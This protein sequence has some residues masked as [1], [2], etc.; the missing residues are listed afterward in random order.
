MVLCK[1]KKY[2]SFWEELLQTSRQCTQPLSENIASRM[3][4]RSK[5]LIKPHDAC[6]LPHRNPDQQKKIELDSPDSFSVA[7]PLHGNIRDTLWTNDPPVL[8]DTWF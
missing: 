8:F 5:A 2:S 4:R 7:A 6:P 1:M 3:I